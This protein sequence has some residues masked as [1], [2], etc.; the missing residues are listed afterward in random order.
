MAFRQPLRSIPAERVRPGVLGGGGRFQ[1]DTFAGGAPGTPRWEFGSEVVE[2][3]LSVLRLVRD[4]D[5]TAAVLTFSGHQE[6]WDFSYIPPRP[7][8]VGDGV[9]FAGGGWLRLYEDGG[10]A[11]DGHN[12]RTAEAAASPALTT[13]RQTLVTLELPGVDIP[14]GGIVYVEAACDFNHTAAGGGPAVG[15]LY[16]DGVIQPRVA[17]YDPGGTGR[18]TVAQHWRLDAL[19]PNVQHVF[20][21]K[22]RKSVAGGTVVAQATH[23][24]LVL[25]VAVEERFGVRS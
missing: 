4:D 9:Q 6:G 8:F 17:I 23:T 19:T 12:G 10:A 15:E 1:S 3:D 7:I 13:A 11:L 25:R 14:P 5:T 16:V 21:L 2:G 20:E 18:A 22:G 24:S